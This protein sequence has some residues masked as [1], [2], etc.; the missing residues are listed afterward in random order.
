M[1]VVTT[2]TCF[3]VDLLYIYHVYHQVLVGAREKVSSHCSSKT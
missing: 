2:L 1:V 3:N